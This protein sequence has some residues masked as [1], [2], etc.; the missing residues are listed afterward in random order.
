MKLVLPDA[1]HARPANLLVRVAS[2]FD[3]EVTIQRGPRRASA[4]LIL[5]ILGLGAAKG[6]EIEV[7]GEGRA[8][9]AVVTLISRN[10]DADLVPE[11]GAVAASGIG[12][13]RAH[14]LL[15]G[16]VSDPE[17]PGE[18]FARAR[19]ELERLIASLP[20]G[21][22]QLFEPEVAILR[23][24]EPRVHAR[25]GLGASFEE[26]VLR[27]TQE[28]PTDLVLDARVRLTS[29]HA[30]L[31]SDREGALV[32]VTGELPPSLVASL[33]PSIA[34]IVA[35]LGESA[36]AHG[37]AGTSHASILARSRGLPLAFVPEHVV[38]SIAPGDLLLVDTT[39]APARVWIS[40]S[41]ALVQEAQGRLRQRRAQE[42][43]EEGAACAAL[44][45]LPIDIKVNLSSTDE[46][47]PPFTGGVGLVRTEL[48][49]ARRMTLPGVEEQASAY[50]RLGARAQGHPVNVRLFD[51]GFDK[52]LPWLPT[53]EAAPGVRGVALLLSH[54]S[55]LRAQ[56]SAIAL[57]RAA[58][59]GV[60]ALVPLVRGL[61]DM[62]AVREASEGLPLEI[63]A[64]I[65][66]PEAVLAIEAIASASDFICIGTNDLTALTLDVP[67]PE[68]WLGLDPAILRQIAAVVLAAH[69]ARL[70]VTVCGEL[71]AHPEGARV[72][73]GLH[74]DALSVMPSRVGAVKQALGRVSLADCEGEATRRLEA[75]GES[76]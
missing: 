24:L 45:H 2:S 6:D 4:R 35:S 65:E 41:D 3:E 73:T 10:F 71:A 12:I 40:P 5:E 63:G 28:S 9:D 59:G 50:A 74:V 46:R 68:P 57:A 43:E 8:R 69:Q 55:V 67:R 42:L 53:P 30:P 16:D 64:M 11:T 58:Q 60:R 27:E 52:P 29:C 61:A 20:P 48:L 15:A 13:G 18:A 62:L 19:E 36:L 56:L 17:S 51:A 54:P 31:P 44:E 21:E 23:E 7:L 25:M 70:E 32:L 33:P 22:A 39:E 66:S 47:I 37:T 26:A 49:F 76:K 38:A 72:L 75:R 14:V 1:L 34:A